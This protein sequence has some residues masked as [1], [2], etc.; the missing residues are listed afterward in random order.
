MSSAL[1]V[2]MPQN[3]S[4]DFWKG[5]RVFLTGHTG[6]KGGWLALWLNKL[7]AVTSGYSLDPLTEPNLFTTAKVKSGIA[8]HQIGDIR[9]LPAL[10]EAMRKFK[11]DIVLHL[12]AQPILRLSYDMP[13]ETYATNVMGTVNVLEAA[14]QT[15]TSKVNL[16]ITTDKCYENKEQIWPYRESDPVGGHDPYS[17]SKG[18][19]ELAVSAYGRS[20][21]NQGT[22]CV[23]SVRAGNVIG[24]GDWAKD[25]LMTDI[26]AAL[27]VNEPPILRNP[28]A[29]RPWQH[30]LEP[31]SGYLLAA[32]YLWQKMPDGPECWNFGPESDSDVPVG[33]VA[34]VVCDL[35]GG[36]I[37]P[38]VVADARKLHEAKLLRLDS[39]KAKAELGWKPRLT[40]RQ[41]LAM[42]VD[43]A[44]THLEGKDMQSITMA[45]IDAYET[46]SS[47]STSL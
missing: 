44:K 39:S 34:D 46:A 13:V 35:W 4:Q 6:F 37:K 19:A 22:A 30:V 41:A 18:C 24:G 15:G 3:P 42:T 40:L 31:L 16:V 38:E 11:P 27:S 17:S 26:I 9:D 1:V 45:Q 23:A 29:I 32:E 8:H 10:L 36:G 7:G 2:P 28:K 12:A 47:H 43:W 5:R 33:S 25:R 21:F 20:F 14:R